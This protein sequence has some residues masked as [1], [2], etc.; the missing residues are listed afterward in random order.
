M[1]S[2]ASV[3]DLTVGVAPGVGGSEGAAVEIGAGRGGPCG[4]A[5]GS[6]NDSL[7][8]LREVVERD[9]VERDPIDGGGESKYSSSGGC[10]NGIVSDLES[11]DIWRLV[12]PDRDLE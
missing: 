7:L 4:R 12:A 3:G 10:V 5:M 9:R 11:L 8:E 1:K 6:V 2:L